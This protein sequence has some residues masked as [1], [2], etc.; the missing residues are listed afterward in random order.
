VLYAFPKEGLTLLLQDFTYKLLNF[1]NIAPAPTLSF[2]TNI[3]I[4]LMRWNVPF[5]ERE[6]MKQ[7]YF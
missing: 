4:V 7:Y 5:C 2:L 6:A 3:F 1:G